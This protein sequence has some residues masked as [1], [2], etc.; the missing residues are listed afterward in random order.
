MESKDPIEHIA[1]RIEAR[2][3][4]EGGW[5]WKREA[6]LPTPAQEY[7][8]SQE[9]RTSE[10]TYSFNETNK[11]I[12]EKAKK[13]Y[14]RIDMIGVNLFQHFT[15]IIAIEIKISVADFK[16]EFSDPDKAA[17]IARFANY[18]YFAVPSGLLDN[19]TKGLL[20]KTGYGLIEVTKQ[21]A[22]IK[23]EADYREVAAQQKFSVTLRVLKKIYGFS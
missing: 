13:Q 23:I 12:R 11:F 1:N 19:S 18:F 17:H 15:D 5:V 22:H 7:I 16:R 2:W 14:R 3:K 8:R 20:T 21:H 4:L 10:T 9:I 6:D